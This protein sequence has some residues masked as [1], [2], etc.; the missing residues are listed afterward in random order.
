[1]ASGTG[2]Y[3]YTIAAHTQ[4]ATGT[5][6]NVEGYTGAVTSY[7]HANCRNGSQCFNFNNSSPWNSS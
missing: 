3:L 4:P 1:M 5:D 7:D 6:L 2:N